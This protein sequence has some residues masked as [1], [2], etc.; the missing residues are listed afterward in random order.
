MGRALAE[1]RRRKGA[2]VQDHPICIFCGGE[3][4]SETEDH[5][6][7]RSFFNE[8]R[9]PEGFVFPACR[10]CNSATR[11]DELL[12]G[13]IAR[14]GDD[15]SDPVNRAEWDR[16]RQGV[17]NNRPDVYRSLLMTPNEVRT[18]LHAYDI[19]RVPGLPLREHP[20]IKLPADDFDAASRRYGFKLGAALHYRHTG[21]V[22]R[23]GGGCFVYLRSNVALVTDG[24]PRELLDMLPLKPTLVRSARV[25]NDQFSYAC[26]HDEAGDFG[27]YV[28]RFRRSFA[29]I[30][31][32]LTSRELV[33]RLDAG[34]TDETLVEPFVWC[35][36]ASP[37]ASSQT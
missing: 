29:L 8:R 14:C 12:L 33:D 31:I 16:A 23:S 17:A 21:R 11:A 5:I 30:I 27:G 9:W 3:H 10:K 25:L 1:S 6:P 37:S 20:I 28:V 35:D 26:G 13:F 7:G 19:E 15:S 4:P 24:L 34:N 22:V 32:L 36:C 2:F 18:A